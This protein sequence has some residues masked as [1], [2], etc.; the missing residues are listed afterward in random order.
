MATYLFTTSP[1]HELDSWEL[2]LALMAAM[3]V[4][5]EIGYRYGCAQHERVGDVGRGHFTAVQASVLALLALL[6]G[7]T[8]NMANVR[9]DM[10]RQGVLDAANNLAA[11]GLRSVELPEPQRAEFQR[12][13][14]EFLAIQADAE[15]MKRGVSPAE[16]SARL[17]RARILHRQMWKI[18]TKEAQSPNPPRVIETLAGQLTEAQSLFRRRIYAYLNRVPDSILIL[19]FS[20]ALG[21]ACVVGFSAGLGQNRGRVQIVALTVFVCGTIHVI[22]QLDRPLTGVQVDQ[23]PLLELQSQWKQEALSP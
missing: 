3:M 4:T 10:R 13:L 2:T 12:L 23:T 18:I 11:I 1:L 7:F 17:A 19:L 20:A 9:F 16:L 15:L 14:R 22:L 21:A 6:L 5:A 8:F